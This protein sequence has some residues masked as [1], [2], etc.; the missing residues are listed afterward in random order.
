[1]LKNLPQTSIYIQYG[2]GWK[3]TLGHSSP[4]RRQVKKFRWRELI[5]YDPLSSLSI[6]GWVESSR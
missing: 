1:M 2:H 3:S 5:V 4:R 6:P